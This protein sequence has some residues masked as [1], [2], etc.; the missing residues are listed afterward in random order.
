MLL[1][2][3]TQQICAEHCECIAVDEKD[4]D[5]VLKLAQTN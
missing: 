3:F 5:S 2:S 1:D 4:L